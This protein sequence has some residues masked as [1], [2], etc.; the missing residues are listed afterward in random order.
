MTAPA[1]VSPERAL[2]NT[3]KA[4]RLLWD[5]RT[6]PARIRPEVIQGAIE[7]A[8]ATLRAASRAPQEDACES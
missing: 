7:E 5:A 6:N 1:P 3:L 2:R 8:E 4:L